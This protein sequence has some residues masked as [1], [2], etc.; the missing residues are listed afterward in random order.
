[1][2]VVTVPLRE[3]FNHETQEFVVLDGFELKLEHS[4]VTLS[5]WESHFKKPFLS[6]TEKSDEELLWYVR[7]MI[8]NKKVPPELFLRMSKQ[9]IQDINDYIAD[10]MTATWF[11]EPKTSGKSREKITA[12]LIYYWMIE[13]GIPVEFEH[14]HLNRLLTLIKVCSHKKAPPKKMSPAE[15]MRMREELNEQ[16]KREMKTTG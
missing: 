15:V 9:N 3:G 7:A 2:L 8:L 12:E 1:V 10:S 11:N 5:K 4:L 14:W 13:F 6:D 16:R